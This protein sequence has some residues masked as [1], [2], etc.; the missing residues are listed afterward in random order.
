VSFDSNVLVY[1]ADRSDR[2][3]ARAVDLLARAAQADCVLALQ[4]LGEFFHAT[5]RKRL[6]PAAEAEATVA[7]WAEIFPLAAADHAA[8]TLALR[9]VREHRLAFWDAL[10][11]A[12]VRRAGCRVLLSEDF[13]DGRELDGVRVVDPFLPDNEALVDLVLP[14]LGSE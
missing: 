2:R 6:L 14:P 10:L 4:S 3:H 7:D 11:W 8:L 9:T 1:M 13:Q 5:T 12:T